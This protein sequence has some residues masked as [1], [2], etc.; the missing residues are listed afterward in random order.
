MN[1]KA[2]AKIAGAE[3]AKARVTRALSEAQDA[4]PQTPGQVKE[5]FRESRGNAHSKTF[6]DRTIRR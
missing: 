2:A 5:T 4:R 3:S 6:A 1:T